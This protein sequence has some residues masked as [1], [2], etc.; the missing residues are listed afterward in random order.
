MRRE[1]RRER[2]ERFGAPE[3]NRSPI[4]PKGCSHY[5]AWFWDLSSMRPPAMEGVAPLRPRDFAEW[6]SASGAALSREDIYVLRSMDGAFRAAVATEQDE[7]R[8]R[9]EAR[10]R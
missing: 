5:E 1:T 7:L 2:N 4:I 3:K 6:A 8:Q 9:E 10:R